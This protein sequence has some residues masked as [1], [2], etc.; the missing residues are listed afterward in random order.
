M[1]GIIALDIDGTLTHKLD[2]IDPR[3]VDGLH[4][5]HDEGWKIALITG[6][7]FSFAW[8]ILQN[9]DFPYL[10]AVQNGADILEMPE[11]H[12]LE[13]NY[14]TPEILPQIE[15][16]YLGNEEDF[17]LYAGIDRGDFCFYRPEK[18]SPRV[19]TYLKK[20]ESLGKEPWR[21][22]DFRFDDNE[23]F[24]LIKCF[25]KESAMRDLFQKLKGNPSI[26]VSLIRDPIDPSLFL[27]LVTHP[28]ANKGSVVHF[29]HDHFQTD[30]VI[31]AGDDGNDIK[32]LQAA[33]IAIAIETAP[34]EVLAVGDI[35]AKK[36]V[37]LGIL[38]ALEEAT[39]RA[40]T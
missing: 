31:A 35:I 38:M 23:K 27:N 3:V 34:K 12:H 39:S 26:E 21:S 17:I 25:G 32:M 13:Q 37:D 11:K 36:P 15:E 22:S 8:H 16:A 9:F 14:L 2:W 19:L 30:H 1:K 10:L 33:N 20:L 28:K 6:R 4:K 24:S 18:F 40:S 7:I 5:Y 29:L